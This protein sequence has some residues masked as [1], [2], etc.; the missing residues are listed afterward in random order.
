MCE[1]ISR[2][3]LICKSVHKKLNYFCDLE[4]FT[5]EIQAQEAEIK[6]VTPKNTQKPTDTLYQKR[7][8]IFFPMTIFISSRFVCDDT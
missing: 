5:R 7:F 2:S 4:S 6:S 3:T 8:T 1:E